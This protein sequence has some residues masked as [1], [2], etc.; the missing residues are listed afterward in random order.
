MFDPF[1][2]RWCC[3][4][5]VILFLMFW[6]C[7]CLEFSLLLFL[8][9]FV[10]SLLSSNSLPVLSCAV[11]LCPSL[12]WPCPAEAS[13]LD[14][15]EQQ[16]NFVPLFEIGLPLLPPTPAAH[17][18][19][20]ICPRS[21]FSNASFRLVGSATKI[22]VSE[23]LVTSRKSVAVRER[24]ARVALEVLQCC[25]HESYCWWSIAGLGHQW[26]SRPLS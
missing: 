17:N 10:S 18:A 5:D 23:K 6:V 12:S 13:T 1:L 4:S 9:F 8:F 24:L 20:S 26:S 11:M 22:G 15:R 21:E 25:L 14:P 2:F 16:E 3:F 19:N 7:G